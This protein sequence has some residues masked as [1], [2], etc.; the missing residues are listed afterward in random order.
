[1]GRA[2]SRTIARVITAA[3]AVSLF[4][5]LLVVQPGCV[6]LLVW[7]SQEKSELLASIADRYEQTR[8]S[9]D[10]RCVDITVVQK[11]SGDAE[12]ELKGAGVNGGA[13]LPEVWSPAASTWLSLL[14]RERQLANA[15]PIIPTSAPSIMQSPLVMAMP[16]PM[17]RLLGWPGKDIS[18][19]DIFAFARDP[20]TWSSR[21][22]PEWGRFKLAK[23]N[24]RISTSGLHT[25]LA[26]YLVAA[27]PL[28]DARV[29]Q[30]MKDVESSVLHYAKTVSSFLVSLWEADNRH[31]LSYVSAI[32]LEEQQ[33]WQYNRGNPE[34]KSAPTRLPPQTRLVAIYPS[35]G[36]FYADHPYVVMPWVTDE[37]KQRAAQK[38][39]DYLR[40]PVIQQE[41]MSN[42]FRGAHYE[43]DG[44]KNDDAFDP[45]RPTTTF[46][47]QTPAVIEQIQ[48]S[49][50]GIRKKANVLV[51]LDSSASMSAHLPSGS[52]SK[53]ALEQD[54]WID[55]QRSFVDGDD[56]GLWALAGSER[57]HVLDVAPM[58]SQRAQLVSEI[59]ALQP[60]GTGKS[61]Y[62]AIAE[63][64]AAV[65]AHFA[66]E[67]I[68]AVVVLTDGKNDDVK[69]G[70]LQGLLRDLL[71]QTD[72][73]RVRVFTIAFGP[74]ADAAA[75]SNIA[76][77]S[78]GSFYGDAANTPNDIKRVILDVVSSF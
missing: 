24:P 70:D 55:A 69:N 17:A 43:T 25:L 78:R 10:L 23:T 77:A 21:G 1:M 51:I 44:I 62:S 12:D 37:R 61:L 16:E 11:A 71:R 30:S 52:D 14:E 22:H 68:N 5:V 19:K 58:A 35:E 65:R 54:A 31:E 3:Y 13:G 18:L 59:N 57:R 34:F 49:W 7:A 76:N 63:G 60:G 9:E 33:I 8:P 48:S 67:R 46:P 36:T 47:P 26:T 56:V 41:F 2:S 64:V 40:S 75:L 4:V 42:R 74:D 53:L 72:D 66:R 73:D 15:T 38:F 20:E 39:L 6:K 50:N 27:G 28:S 32:A 29:T 45:N